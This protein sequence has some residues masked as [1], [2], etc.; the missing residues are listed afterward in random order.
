MQQ[1]NAFDRFIDSGSGKRLLSRHDLN[2]DGI[3][4]VCG[5]DPNCDF[6]GGH[7]NPH[8]FTA[9]G[10]LKDVIKKAVHTERF[11]TWG[12]GGDITLLEIKRL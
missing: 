3:W 10:K 12:Y 7:Y 1:Q 6:G 2:D 8:L 4:R 9:S 5:E 11:W